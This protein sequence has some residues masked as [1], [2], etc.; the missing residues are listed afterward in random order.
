MAEGWQF[1]I[2]RGGTFTDVV[3]RAPDGRIATAKVLSEVA[4]ETVDAGVRGIRRLLGLPPGAALPDG[5]I[6]AAKVGTT[7][8]TNALLERKG[9][10]VLFLVTEGF[11]D[12][13]RIGYQN[14]PRLFDLEIRLPAPLYARVAEVPGRLDAG[15]REIAPLDT[16]AARQALRTAQTAGISAVAI[17]L[18]HAHVNPAHEVRL[19]D[20]ARAEGF[21]QVTASHAVSRLARIVA[22]ADTA[23]VDAYLSPVLR[24][25]VDG[26]ARDL[27]HGRATGRLYFMQSSGGLAEAGAFR[28]CEAILSGPAGGVVGMARSGTAAGFE[29]LIGFDMGGTS[30]DVSHYAGRYERRFDAE[31]A[32]VRVRVPMLDIHTVAAGGGSVCGFRDGRLQ[33]GPE[34]AGASPGPACYRNGG[35]LTVTDCNLALGRLQP[36]RFPAVFGPAA[37]APP[38][39]AAAL[40]RL[41]EVAAQV[42]GAGVPTTGRE[43]LAEGFLRIAVENMANAIRRISTERGRDVRAY[44]LACF[45]GAGGQHA[46]QVA[47]ALGMRRVLVH[48]LAGVLS[49]YGM[50]LAE[51]RAI[52]EAQFDAPLDA[53][54]A[55]AAADRLRRLRAEARAALAAQGEPAAR[56]RATA[57][58]RY[59]GAVGALEVPWGTPAA[60]ARAFAARHR[61]RF[62]FTDPARPLR[63]E[64]LAVEAT[65][66]TP[67]LAAPTPPAGPLPPPAARVRAWFAGGWRQVP[68]HLRD[69]LPGGARIAGPAIVAEATGTVVVEPGWTAHVDAAANLVLERDAPAPARQRPPRGGGRPDPV[70]LELMANRFMA[71]AEE[72]GATLAST[73]WSVNIKE[74]LDFSCAVFDAAGAL[75]ANAPHVPVHLGSMS[76]A[77]R[78]VIRAA[79]GAAADGSAWVLN[80][81]FEGGTH[82]PDITVVAPVMA[83]G[84]AAFWVAARGHHADVGGTTPGSS[85]PD[86]R[87]LAE[88]GAVIPVTPLV[89]AGRFREAE[90]RAIL[91]A[92]R[93]PARAPDQ[94]IADLKAQVAATA[95]GR[96]GLR[97]MIAGHGLAAVRAYAGH[98]QD[99]AEAIV[100]DRLRRLPGGRMVLPL[101]GGRQIA[102]AVA[103]DPADGSA[104]VDFTGTSPQDP[105][106]RNAPLAV[107]RAVVMYVLR[108]LIGREVPLNEGCLR[109]V[110]LVVPPGTMLNPAP[111]A[112]VIAGN[113]E[114]SQAACNALLGALGVLAAGQGTMNN[115]VWG[116]ARLQNYETL[117]GGAGAGPGFAGASGV[118]SHMTNTR[119]T[120]PEVLEARFPVRLEAMGYRRGSGGAGRWRG[121]DGIR[122][123]LRLLEP[124]TVTLLTSSRE[125]APFGMEGGG[126]GATGVNRVIWPDGRVEW[127]AGD[128]R[129]DLPAG[130]IV[131]IETPGGGGW[132]EP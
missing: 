10:P 19:A 33:V 49:A 70:R 108:L 56:L 106:N 92:G 24:A 27:G 114:V 78:A 88:E 68:L 67:A 93:W 94:N 90:L 22:R 83:G 52:R 12:L 123:R 77:V 98:I 99:N 34:S 5:A 84:R 105:G 9:A 13:L 86:S 47:E 95:A 102:V 66:P 76:D 128:D 2:D 36:D 112:A 131:E 118:Q 14:R 6:A 46:L 16:A 59:A 89:E 38:D 32:G 39:P 125:V 4:G 41:D 81:P 103:I 85:P 25:Y 97:A 60:M 50:G 58:L 74:R 111:G 21:A 31:V 129:R 44:T 65:G 69:G 37:D 55:A 91:G 115:L 96:R 7:V 64:M 40:A 119:M 122:R 87:S 104:T 109:P 1:W 15:G 121:G 117:A 17:G 101:D 73:A 61:A 127:L 29:R 116:N 11:A 18:L 107:C 79:A 30:T 132:G 23:V 130:A 42:A 63:F 26:L 45:G 28:G 100:R 35:P 124:M 75:V 3:G 62:G 51:V 82:L 48:P 80:S 113:T 71:V 126:P 20:L 54:H 110:R 120:D 8:A 72:M 43:A 57:H 53:D